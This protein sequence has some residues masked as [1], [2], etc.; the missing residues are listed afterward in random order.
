ML[1]YYLTCINILAWIDEELSTILKLIDSISKSV[2]GI[3]RN[4]RTVYSALNLAL[5]WLILL[6]AMSHDCLALTGS[7]NIGTKT[8]DTTRRN[9]ELDVYTLAL[10]LHRGHL[11]LTAGNHINHLRCKL[12]R[13]I[14][15]ELFY[16]LMLLAINLL[17]NNLGLTNL[18]LIALATHGLDKHREVQH[19]T[20]RNNPLISRILEWCY[21]QSKVL[22]E[23]FLQT[24]VD[25]ARG[26]KLTLL[27]EEWR[28]VDHEEH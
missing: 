4:H 15:G 14:D 24:I 3:H 26:N 16:R 18:K 1:T 8:D 10:T 27:T 19:T 7:E 11:A 2:T 12:L 5:V 23:L 17:I 20:A 28:I 13:H 25:V 22:L 6:K 9:I 21:T